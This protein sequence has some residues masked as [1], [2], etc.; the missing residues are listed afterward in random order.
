MPFVG[1]AVRVK[2]DVSFLAHAH[3]FQ[4]TFLLCTNRTF[5]FCGDIKF[6]FVD[7]PPTAT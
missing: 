5:S 2:V 4:R 6:G 7:L 3:V 1:A